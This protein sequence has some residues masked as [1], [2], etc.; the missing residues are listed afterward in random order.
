MT[1]LGNL[2]TEFSRIDLDTR[3]GYARVARVKTNEQLGLPN[4]CAF[5][6]MRH[7]IDSQKG[8]ARCEDE[9]ELLSVITSHVGAPS[10]ITRIY[11]SGF[12]QSELSKSIHNQQDPKY[13]LDIVSTGTDMVNFRE[14]KKRLKVNESGDWLP[15]L[16]VE[17]A[18]YDNSL[19]RQIN[20]QPQEDS[21]GL[22]RLPTG[23]VILMA[24]QLLDVMQYLH[25]KHSRAYIDW[26]PEH[27]FW[28]G[29]ERQ[30]KLID[31]NV[32]THLDDDH[33]RKQNIQDDLRLFCG[34]VL[35]IGLT[36]ID[37]DTPTHLTHSIG[38]R[39]TTDLNSPVP[40]IR[41]RYWTDK[42]EF[43]QRDSTLD[44]NIKEI[45]RMGLDPNRGFDTIQKFKNTLLDYAKNELGITEDELTSK[46]EPSSPYFKSL[47]ELRTAQKQ[48][49]DAQRHLIDGVESHGQ[50]LEFLRLFN[51]IKRALK[52]FPAS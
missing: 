27:I 50:T 15:Y 34:A 29:F 52:N 28:D 35:Y 13:D 2:Y 6:L 9:I 11:D 38:P 37:P 3:G 10:A 18:P 45:I 40:E 21:S 12:V 25:E 47:V 51:T 8:L 44:E 1:K 14:Q 32:T 23:E 22:F 20:S 4:H 19:L 36:F 48:L 46:A 5:K 39:P 17:L 41:R 31:W 30:V 42:P 26:K 33:G 16:L 43:H 49:L 7:E 24:F